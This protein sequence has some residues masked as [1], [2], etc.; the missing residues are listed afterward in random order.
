MFIVLSYKVTLVTSSTLK[1]K[2]KTLC[3]HYQKTTVTSKTTLTQL[4]KD[5]ATLPRNKKIR[6]LLKQHFQTFRNYL[7]FSLST[8]VLL[9]YVHML[10][11]VLKAHT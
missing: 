6:L 11:Y 9:F 8:E 7:L 10:L 5:Q 1:Q 3:P 4:C 2:K